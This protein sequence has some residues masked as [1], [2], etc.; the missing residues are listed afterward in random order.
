MKRERGDANESQRVVVFDSPE[1][2]AAGMQYGLSDGFLDFRYLNAPPAPVEKPR[3]IPQDDD[4]VMKA[5]VYLAPKMEALWR[6]RD[7]AFRMGAQDHVAYITADDLDRFLVE[8]KKKPIDLALRGGNWKGSCF[9]RSRWFRLTGI[10]VQSTRAR[11]NKTDLACWAL[12]E[13]CR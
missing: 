1:A 3:G 12:R 7:A 10:V 2:R 5:K 4:A 13:S 9:L 6:E 8:W 11:M